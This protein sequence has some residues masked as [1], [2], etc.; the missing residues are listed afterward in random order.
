[1]LAE[2]SE[3]LERFKR[4]A[5]A[6]SALNH[7]NICTIYDVDEDGGRSFIAMEWLEGQTLRDL[8]KNT[9]L[10]T[11]NSKIGPP[12]GLQFPVSSFSSGSPLPLDTLLDL[13]IQI[14]DGLDAAHAKGIIHRDIKPANIWVTLRGQAEDSG[15]RPGEIN[16]AG[17]AGLPPNPRWRRK[18][19]STRRTRAI[20]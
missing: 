13:A 20:E 8:L 1:M 2:S 3:A 14:A 7:P 9:K 4:E 12:A 11:G 6:A 15:F 17:A 5:Q 19:A 10:E 18:A 16:L